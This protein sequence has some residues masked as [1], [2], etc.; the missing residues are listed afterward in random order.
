VSGTVIGKPRCPEYAEAGVEIHEDA[1]TASETV[2]IV[3]DPLATDG[4]VEAAIRSLARHGADICGCSFIGDFPQLYG[5]R[6]MNELGIEIHVL[7][8]SREE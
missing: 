4:T 8:E 2:V 5:G 1:V 6:R 3:E 7:C